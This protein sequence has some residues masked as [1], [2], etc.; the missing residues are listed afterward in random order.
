MKRAIAYLA[1]LLVA[2]CMAV[3]LAVPNLSREPV[4]PFLA[5]AAVAILLGGAWRVGA[6]CDCRP[7]FFIYGCIG[8]LV[9]IPLLVRERGGAF[10]QYPRDRADDWW[11]TV[12]CIVMVVFAGLACRVLAAI[13]YD[14]QRRIEVKVGLCRKCGYSLRGLTVPRCPECGTPFDW[15]PLDSLNRKPMDADNGADADGSDSA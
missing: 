6:A 13:S 8:G 9:F 2:V 7:L 4:G 14:W 15:P 11:V 12:S 5:A 3:S 1:L 10:L